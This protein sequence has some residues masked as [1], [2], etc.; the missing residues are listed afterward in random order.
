[1]NATLGLAAEI[2]SNDLSIRRS[3]R[4]EAPASAAISLAKFG[5]EEGGP[6]GRR[7]VASADGS[8][9]Y[10]A[11]SGGIVRIATDDLTTTGT[12]LEGSAIDAL[13]LT[14][15][16]ETL[17][18]LVRQGGRIV[19]LDTASGE[20][21][22]A[23][24]RRR[25]RPAGGDRSLV[26]RAIVSGRTGGSPP[27]RSFSGASQPSMRPCARRDR[28]VPPHGGTHDPT[29]HRRGCRRPGPGDR[30]RWLRRVRPDPARGQRGAARAAEPRPVTGRR[31]RLGRPSG[32]PTTR[33]PV[34]IARPA[35][36]ISPARGPCR[37]EARRAT[38]SAS[39]WPISPPRATPSDEPTG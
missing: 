1:M 11:G 23:G 6:V 36:A 21:D 33:P 19:E 27:D 16:G 26:A 2:D 38:A 17:Y 3:A 20:R 35:S 13:A 15:D 4:F 8:M 34:P 28:A 22:R 14:P 24:A 7:V 32:E 5:H 10:A 9:L 12:F 29:A 25:V 39:S 37:R 18:A 31:R 30:R